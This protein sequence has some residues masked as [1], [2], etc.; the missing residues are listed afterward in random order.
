MNNPILADLLAN[1][2]EFLKS[3]ADPLYTM[4]SVPSGLTAGHVW[5]IRVDGSLWRDGRDARHPVPVSQCKALFEY[6]DL[7]NPPDT[8]TFRV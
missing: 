8:I 3:V 6:L 5:E 4:S 2:S 1:K 7:Y